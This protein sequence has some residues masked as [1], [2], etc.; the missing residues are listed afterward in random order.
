MRAG[1]AG[2]CGV[3]RAARAA[4]TELRGEPLEQPQAKLQRYHALLQSGRSINAELR[5]SKGYRNPDFLQKI[6][7]FFGIHE[8]GSCYPRELYDPDALLAEDYYD[9]LTA[10]QRT[11]AEAR[12]AERARRGVVEFTTGGMQPGTVGLGGRP[13]LPQQPA[14][15]QAAQQRFIRW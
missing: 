5:K 6:V 2:A 12:E 7:E 15:G 9:A 10:A 3:V 4:S 13:I 8:H 14:P 11:Q 1:A